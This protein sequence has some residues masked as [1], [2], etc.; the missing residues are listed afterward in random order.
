MDVKSAVTMAVAK[1]GFRPFSDK[2]VN[3]LGG[4]VEW[5]FPFQ[6]MPCTLHGWRNL[7]W[8]TA[9]SVFLW[10]GGKK[11]LVW[12]TVAILVLAPSKC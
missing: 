1:M 5:S 4:L 3:L 6:Y 10:V 11:G 12:F 7:A 2:Q 9:F 8:P